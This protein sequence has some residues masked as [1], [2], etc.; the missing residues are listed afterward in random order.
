MTSSE[1]YLAERLHALQQGAPI[2]EALAFFDALPPVDFAELI[3]VWRGSGLPTGNPLDGVLEA[4]GWWG[5]RFDSEDDVHP[6]VFA[7]PRGRFNVNPR[8]V[9][10]GLAVRWSPLISRPMVARTARLVL[11]ALRTS[12]PA[13]RLRMTTYRGVATATMCYDA[14]PIHDVFRQVDADTL[15]GSMDLRGLPAPFLFVLRRYGLEQD[16]ARGG[17]S[18]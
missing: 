1:R 8:L 12:R 7:G 15:L 17:E 14:L 10:L 5:K 16:T 4:T 11:R 9:P 3:G 2:D 18:R 13:A 6:L